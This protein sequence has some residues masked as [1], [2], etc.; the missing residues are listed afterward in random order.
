[1]FAG[2]PV[3]FCDRVLS[4][5]SRVRVATPACQAHGLGRLAVVATETETEK[6]KNSPLLLYSSGTVSFFSATGLLSG[7]QAMGSFWMSPT[8][9]VMFPWAVTALCRRPGKAVVE[10]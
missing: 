1:M 10:N 6:G 4:D 8:M 5:L 3:R 2:G 9:G 7:L